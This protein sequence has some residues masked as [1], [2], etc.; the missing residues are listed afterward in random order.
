MPTVLNIKGYRFYFYAGD[1]NEPAHV[2]VE[3][4]EGTAKIWLE[5]TLEA[6]YFY[7]FKKKEIKDIMTIVEDNYELLKSKWYEYFSK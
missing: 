4:G 2:H 6:K 1:E 3:K 7:Y 5:P